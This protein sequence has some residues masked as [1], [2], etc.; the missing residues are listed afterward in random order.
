M[1]ARQKVYFQYSVPI[2]LSSTGVLRFTQTRQRIHSIAAWMESCYSCQPIRHLSQ[3]SILSCCGVQQGDSLGPLGFALALQPLLEL[4]AV[5]SGLSLNVW[6]LMIV[7]VMG[8]PKD[9]AVALHIVKE[10]WL[11]LG[12]H[13]NHS[14]SLLFIPPGPSPLSL[15]TSPSPV[16]VSPFSAAP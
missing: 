12:L 5:V 8:S 1:Q 13:L 9:L 15:Q 16:V 6:Y 11:T 3:D 10:E 7:L 4:K 2:N 14:K